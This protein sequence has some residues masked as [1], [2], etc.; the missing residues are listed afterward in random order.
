[1]KGS[2]CTD[3]KLQARAF[4]THW[5]PSWLPHRPPR[6][7]VCCK[8]CIVCCTAQCRRRTSKYQCSTWCPRW[9]TGNEGVPLLRP[10]QGRASLGLWGSPAPDVSPLS[11]G[12][13]PLSRHACI[14]CALLCCDGNVLTRCGCALHLCLDQGGASL[15]LWGSP[16]PDVSPLSAGGQPLSRH[17]CITCALLCCDGKVLTRCGCVLHLCLDQGGQRLKGTTHQTW[18][19]LTDTQPNLVL[20]CPR[21]KQL[22]AVTCLISSAT[23]CISKYCSVTKVLRTSNLNVLF[24]A[25][26]RSALWLPKFHQ[27]LSPIGLYA[28]CGRC[29]RCAWRASL[30]F[31]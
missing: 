21:G 18:R 22:K 26:I 31:I 27:Y 2:C 28:S 10:R 16:A 25:T 9:V 29:G 5:F 13:Q 8:V 23:L 7:W 14:T 30:D 15:G 17:A 20:H 1:M 19:R 12:G 6:C 24:C 11:A 3:S 4:P